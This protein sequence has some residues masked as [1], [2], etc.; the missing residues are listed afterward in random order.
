MSDPNS[1]PVVALT[2][3]LPFGEIGI[4][5]GHIG[6]LF[7][8]CVERPTAQFPGFSIVSPGQ[9]DDEPELDD[10]EDE[11]DEV[12]DVGATSHASPIAVACH[13]H[14]LVLAHWLLLFP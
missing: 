2:V 3:E 4:R 12:E 7:E 5:T 11:E 6:T 10:E 9:E 8:Q 14:P 1:A 13:E